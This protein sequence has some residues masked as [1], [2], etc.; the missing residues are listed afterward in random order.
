MHDIVKY[1]A[2]FFSGALVSSC[3]MFTEAEKFSLKPV[4][5]HRF[6]WSQ[7]KEYYNL[8]MCF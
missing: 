7:R 1:A 8:A 6:S 2:L 3:G 4:L 5:Q